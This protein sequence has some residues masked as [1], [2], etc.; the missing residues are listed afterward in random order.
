M[1]FPG[2]CPFESLFHRLDGWRTAR[3]HN[4]SNF[5]LSSFRCPWSQGKYTV[6][7]KPSAICSSRRWHFAAPTSSLS[8]ETLDK[9]HALDGHLGMEQSSLVFWCYFPPLHTTLKQ[10]ALSQLGFYESPV[11]SCHLRGKS[12]LHANFWLPRMA[13]ISGLFPEQT[14]GAGLFHLPWVQH[15]CKRPSRASRMS[16]PPPSVNL[17][18]WLF[19]SQ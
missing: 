11:W 7:S 5:P 3:P 9:S 2:S 6:F 18:V 19:H 10:T 17:P 14:L 13:W 1:L 16:S 12:E 4:L 8:S 15:I